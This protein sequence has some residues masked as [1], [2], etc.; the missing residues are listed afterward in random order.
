MRNQPGRLSKDVI[1]HWPEVFKDVEVQSVPLKYLH[2]ITV[3]FIN[4]KS[5]IINIDEQKA[6]NE[7]LDYGLEQLFEEYDGEIDTIDF[8]LNTEK[9]R[10]DIEKRTKQFLKKRK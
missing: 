2:S 6:E 5:W 9:V 1:A 10:N 7:E 4:G 3:N 8:R